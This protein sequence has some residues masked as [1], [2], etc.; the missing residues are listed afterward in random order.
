MMLT[1]YFAL[2]LIAQIKVRFLQVINTQGLVNIGGSPEVYSEHGNR[3]SFD[4]SS[5]PGIPARKLLIKTKKQTHLY[6][7]LR[8]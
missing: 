5:F 7:L 8:Q 4:C 6:I 1:K 2:Y 3:T